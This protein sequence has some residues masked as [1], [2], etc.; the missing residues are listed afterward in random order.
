[1][2]RI[3]FQTLR[4]RKSGFVGSFIALLFAVSI[5]T[6]CGILIDSG[7]RSTIPTERY[8]GVDLVLTANRSVKVDQYTSLSL[9]NSGQPRLSADVLEK[10]RTVK[11]V[12]RAFGE[13][14]FGALALGRDGQPVSGPPLL[15][16]NWT[17]ASLTPMKLTAGVAP[18][19]DNQA[20]IDANLAK[21]AGVRIG[22][23][24][25]IQ[26][27]A[28][29]QT[30][31][32]SGIAQ[33]SHGATLNKQSAI[34]FSD[35][36]ATTLAGHPG[37]LTAIG[38]IA[39]DGFHANEVLKNIQ[40]TVNDKVTIYSTSDRGL[41][42]FSEAR[43]T[44]ESLSGIGGSLGGIAIVVAIFV[45]ASTLTLAVSQRHREVALLRATGATPRQVRRM[46]RSEAT[47][48]AFVAGGVGI[49]PGVL[50]AQWLRR[51][52]IDRG[53]MP[54]NMHLTISWI[55]MVV[56]VGIGV[57]V[58]WLAAS[59]AAWRAAAVHPTQALRD[60]TPQPRRMGII[61]ILSGFLVLAG[62]IVLVPVAMSAK[63]DD[64]AAVA[65]GVVMV[66][67]VAVGLLGPLLAKFATWVATP[68]LRLFSP[69]TG[70]LAAANSYANARR[71]AGATTPL[72]LAIALA[73]VGVGAQTTVIHAASKEASG[74][75]RA[76]Y[77]LV[78]T[79]P[80]LPHE[81]SDRVRQLPGVSATTSLVNTDVVGGDGDLIATGASEHGLTDT[82]DL[83][84]TAGSLRDFTGEKIAVSRLAETMLK[85][86]VGGKANIWLADGTKITPTVV[87]IYSRG[88]GF[89]DVVLPRNILVNHTPNDT[90]DTL[91]IRQ[92]AGVDHAKLQRQLTDLANEYIGVSVADRKSYT[93]SQDKALRDNA[94]FNYLIFA[95]LIAFTVVAMINTLVMTVLDRSRELALIRLIGGTVKQV[96]AMLRW[97]TLVIIGT[98]LVFGG[99]I[100]A[101]TLVP[102]SAGITDGL[103]W[104][105]AWFYAFLIGVVT[106][107]AAASILLPARA[108]LR[109]I[110]A[111]EI[112]SRE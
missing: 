2:I 102:F 50:G 100:S 23:R 110:P 81:L 91:L 92:S 20:V 77:V 72:I 11:G 108:V 29:P 88:L 18:T 75:M 74:G 48:L 73:F 1:M 52:L 47:L 104:L 19:T 80:G 107:L 63:G 37:Q 78:G 16:H 67:M 38:V 17:S 39:A 51:Q 62:G 13:L 9:P 12:S 58:S 84:V 27:S 30:Y 14:T 49:I 53:M 65:L 15:G 109:R 83:D 59:S 68:F 26:V 103:P 21:R 46:I 86:Q 54:E 99:A 34:F 32:I 93:A 41:A 97:E 57:V 33:P 28:R 96:R 90:D 70:Y 87:A 6:A 64:A 22:D 56:A 71:L 31:T 111:V 89:G 76:D 69:A 42:E 43:E 66:L 82:L 45:V 95:V 36:Q 94:W 60:A 105:P 44:R 101:A 35:K 85:V 4:N 7:V 40:K 25:H 5:I 79:N 8:H 112:G 55:P 61:R 106:S 24:L 98:A 10:V 3:A